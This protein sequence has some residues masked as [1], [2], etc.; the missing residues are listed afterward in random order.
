LPHVQRPFSLVCALT[1]LSGL[2]NISPASAQNPA[3][4]ENTKLAER[5][6]KAGKDARGAVPLLELWDNWD[7]S[8]PHKLVGELERLAKHPAVDTARKVLIETMLAQAKLRLGD[9]N[10]VGK[11]FEELGYVT[12]LRVIG[13]FDNEGKRGFD[14]E[15]PVEKK[16][17]EA[18]DLVAS[19]PGRERPVAWR[20]LPDVVRSGF[21]PFGAVMRP[22]ENVCGLAETFVQS[23]R[24]RPLSL[25]VGAGGAVKVYWNGAQVLRDAAYRG[26]SPDRSVAL[27]AARAGWN[28]LLVKVCTTTTA[29]GFQLRIGDA[30]GGVASGLNYAL[31]TPAALD[32]Q[33]V[34]NPKLPAAP[35]APL[36]YFEE[37]S[38]AAKPA[39]Q[40]LADAARFLDL[41]N[42]DDPAE[43]RAK[44]LA[45]RAAELEP[46]IEHLRLAA[47][48]AEERA[49]VMRFTD[50]A[51]ALKPMDPSVLLLRAALVANGPSPEQA[52]IFLD[53]IPPD[54]ANAAAASLLRARIVRGL[55]LPMVALGLLRDLDKRIGPSVV[56][57]REL[58]DQESDASQANAAQD[59][60]LRLLALRFDDADTRRALIDDALSRG[61]KKTVLEHVD[62][63]RAL[64]PGSVRTLLYL[65]DVYD[66]LGRDDL[67]LATYRSAQEIA[68]E[69]SGVY[70]AHARA[71]LRAQQPAA[72]Y[73][74]LQKALALKPQD[75]E[76][77]ELLEEVR[78][79]ARADEEYAVPSK[80]LLNRRKGDGG[81]PYRVLQDLTVKTVFENGLGS[82]FRQLAV[83]IHDQEGARRFRTHSFQY[84]PDAQ[85]VD[86]RLARVYRKD[87][88][89][90][91]SVRTY[92]QQLGEPWYRIYYDTR[93]V[94]VVFPD[95]EP[96][97][98]VEVRYR[99]DDVA[100]R[101]LFADYFGDVELW[102]DAVP[103]ADKRYVLITPLSREIFE[104]KPNAKGIAHT[105]RVESKRRIDSYEWQ[106]V[107]ALLTEEGMP[108]ITEESPYLHVST[109]RG[110][111][112]VGRWYWGLI[113]DQLYAD[114]AL[115]R[116]VAELID[117]KKTTRDKVVSIHDWVVNHTRYV[118]LEFG[119]HGFLPYRV[120]LI[121]QRGFGDCKDKASVMYTMLR[122]A[123]IDARIVLLRTRHNGAMDSV[124]A[125]LAVFDHAITYVPE[126]DLYL[127]GTAEHS[128]ITELPSEDQGAM[129]LLVGPDGSELRHTPYLPADQ[130]RRTR[131]LAIALEA[132][133]SA[134]VDGREEVIGSDAAG[135]RQYYEAEGTRAER[136]ER[137]LGTI[138]PGVELMSQTFE[139][140]AELET[141]VRYSYRIRVPRFGRFDGATMQVAP[142]VLSDLVRSMA[143]APTRKQALDLG[144]FSTYVEE[145]QYSA[146][147]GMH[148]SSVPK[149]A[150]VSSTWGRLSLRYAAEGGGLKVHTEFQLT[151]TRVSAAEYPEFRRWVEA[152]D[153]LLRQRVGVSRGAS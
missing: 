77:R 62:V 61:D 9:P 42:S 27:V 68:P 37:R 112:D 144:S 60:R 13:P 120:P 107:P 100:H 122:E 70:L 75:A 123:G 22:F 125:S 39:A 131:A 128:G 148:F 135:Y 136:F 18:P 54:N 139:S 96:G 33:P 124:P 45:E 133:G 10:A 137:T 129:V 14:A 30:Q 104:N 4:A 140:L 134:R 86:L 40:L 8:T 1:C 28:R 145:R 52:L 59:D 80:E 72:A 20:E 53:Q 46:S 127:D 94:E 92:E 141:P 132:D 16:R 143:R 81:Y 103:I 91:E 67:V 138:Y 119:I 58:V 150:E 32:I 99:I 65:A 44:Q 41:T 149:D 95:L 35:Q 88:R 50:K 117:G 102:Q 25:W 82:T 93:A 114:Q 97:D 105:Q 116:T 147:N 130:N 12:H 110:W 101:N 31:T 51:A 38:K 2:L 78:P 83:E 34:A 121:V 106:D 153:Q 36:A 3:D 63:L 146:P 48:L 108:G 79:A 90:L 152:A 111:E 56:A 98:V 113:R 89:E 76:T 71:L 24:A 23:E 84:D 49:E 11:R 26:P 73:E 64:T 57:L 19:Y 74:A 115:K 151:R 69:A 118:G 126:L 21:V 15:S 6:I 66:A 17:T 29:W 55:E 109:Y 142:S 87:G 7:K 5:V 47:K 85:H 43:R